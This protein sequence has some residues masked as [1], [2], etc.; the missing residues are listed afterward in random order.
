M[1]GILILMTVLLLG[2][3]SP[4]QEQAAEN[5]SEDIVVE[6]PE[7]EEPEVVPDEPAE[8]PVEE[9]VEEEPVETCSDFD[10]KDSSVKGTT[11]AFDNV[12]TDTCSDEMT[13]K[14]YYCED[15]EAKSELIECSEGFKCKGGQCI[16]GRIEC[17]D[18]DGGYDIYT[19]G[20]VTIASL[21]KGE[22]IDKCLD[23]TR[24]KEY[25]C[26]DDELAIAEVE[27]EGGC[28]RAQCLKQ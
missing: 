3:I 1:R 9:L 22:Y 24:L 23:G 5:A 11:T 4:A 7:S 27:C 15:G 16:K 13:V 6:E 19:A 25:Y 18:T 20:S 28:F 21:L 12:F 8:E 10:G 26:E 2:C 14:E 17:T